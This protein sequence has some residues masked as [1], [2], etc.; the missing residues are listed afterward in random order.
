M[1]GNSRFQLWKKS[2]TNSEDS[3][4]FQSFSLFQFLL[5]VFFILNFVLIGII[6][7]DFYF[8]EENQVEARAKVYFF[9]KNTFTAFYGNNSYEK[10]KMPENSIINDAEII[11]IHFTQIFNLRKSYVHNLDSDPII[12][13]DPEDGWKIFA[14]INALAFLILVFMPRLN[15]TISDWSFKESTHMYFQYIWL[16]F[17]VPIA[18]SLLFW[19]KLLMFIIQNI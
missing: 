11:Y 9:D 10:F 13:I 6:I 3:N 5:R 15:K 8:L 1:P 4:N 19:Y 18:F 14:V 17:F 16:L 12:V 7:V 2:R